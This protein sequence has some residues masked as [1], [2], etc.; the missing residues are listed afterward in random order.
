MCGIA[1]VVFD[2]VRRRDFVEASLSSM[3]DAQAARGPDGKF[4]WTDGRV[5]LGMVRLAIVGSE[6]RGRQPITGPE[7]NRLIFNGEL[8]QPEKVMAATGASFDRHDC[9]GAALLRLLEKRGLEGLRDFSAMFAL[10]FYQHE[11]GALLLARDARGQKPLYRCRLPNGW[12]FASTIAALHTVAGPFQLRTEAMH[13][14][15]IFKSVGGNGSAFIGVD[16]IPAGCWMRISAEGAASE[17]R[18][19]LPQPLDQTLAGDPKKTRE[20]INSA[21]HMRVPERFRS[22]IF[23]SGGLDSS[24]VAAVAATTGMQTKPHVLTV[25]YDVGGWQD[26]HSLAVRL[27]EELGLQQQSLIV[28]AHDVPELLRDT[29]IALED[30]NHD[31]VVVPTLALARAASRETKVVLTGDGA[32][33]FWGGYARFDNPP[34]SLETYLERTMVF[35]PRELGLAHL[36]TSYLSGTALLPDDTADPLDRILCLETS[37]RLRNYHLARIDKLSMSAGLEAR[38]PFL[39]LKVTCYAES[40]TAREKRLGAKPKGLLI[41]AFKTVLPA[42]LL[43]RK[44]Q[45]FTVP[46]ESWLA[47]PL[48][49]F[50]HDTLGPSAFVRQFADPAPLLSGL[51][52]P[53]SATPCAQRLWSLLHLE[54][55]YREFAR[56]MAQTP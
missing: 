15:L 36:P 18:W 38:A 35:H 24:I 20:L 43:Q 31:P 19:F 41:D 27:A 2:K 55:W 11:S 39:D 21:V 54:I 40:L 28:D 42:W 56:R 22:S 49:T 17:G 45:P 3:C 51:L 4:I 30:P 50:A 6:S 16:Q 48:R 1:C 46:I 5:G 37:N 8:Y 44:K 25:G 29:A 14:C 12:A 33:E 7:G 26:E 10:A 52:A 23:L 53:A 13:E 32:D 34:Q 47:G 9:D